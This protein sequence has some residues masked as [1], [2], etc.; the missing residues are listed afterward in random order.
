[1]SQ[2]RDTHLLPLPT[3]YWALRVVQA[4]LGI[5]LLCICSVYLR[6]CFWRSRC[7]EEPS[8]LGLY[9]MGMATGIATIAV[10][11]YIIITYHYSPKMCNYTILLTFDLLLVVLWTA[12][13]FHILD[14]KMLFT[15]FGKYSDTALLVVVSNSILLSIVLLLWTIR[16][17]TRH[18]EPEQ[19][20]GVFS[21]NLP[22]F[23]GA[24]IPRRDSGIFSRRFSKVPTATRAEVPVV[25]PVPGAARQQPFQQAE[26]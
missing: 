20:P 3:L 18:Q 6:K 5:A 4:C 16:Y 11:L 9:S 26:V 25:S 1:M 19:E 14:V 8:I 7:L 12:S 22:V 23:N 10:F 2:R 13:L 21:T 15:F 17:T 24:H